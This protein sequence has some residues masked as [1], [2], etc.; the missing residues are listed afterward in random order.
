MTFWCI[1]HTACSRGACSR[2]TL[3][4]LLLKCLAILTLPSPRAGTNYLHR[5]LWRKGTE[6]K[7]FSTACR[8]SLLKYKHYTFHEK[9]I[10]TL[11]N[12][13]V[14]VVVI[15]NASLFLKWRSTRDS[16]KA[17]CSTS[18][19][20]VSFSTQTRLIKIVAGSHFSQHTSKRSK[21]QWK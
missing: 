13:C 11:P 20:L 8:E 5:N 12:Y 7:C 9:L 17:G 14:M 10:Q 21:L 19:S 4:S 1:K 2:F 16:Q 15:I 6:R 18:R 3:S